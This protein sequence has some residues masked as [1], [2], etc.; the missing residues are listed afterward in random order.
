MRTHVVATCELDALDA[1]RDI[2]RDARRDADMDTRS[3][4]VRVVVPPLIAPRTRL[5][6]AD[7]LFSGFT[8]CVRPASLIH[9]V[10]QGPW[11][12][13]AYTYARFLSSLSHASSRGSAPASARAPIRADMRRVPSQFPGGESGTKPALARW[14]A[15]RRSG[16][17]VRVRG[18]RGAA[19]TCGVRG[20]RG[21]SPGSSAARG[22]RGGT[23]SPYSRGCSRV[24]SE[25]WACRDGLGV[26]EASAGRQMYW[27]M[28]AGWCEDEERGAGVTAIARGR[29]QVPVRAGIRGAMRA[30][31]GRLCAGRGW[32]EH[33]ERGAGVG[34]SRGHA[35]MYCPWRSS[36]DPPP[37]LP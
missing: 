21:A 5:G 17:Q 37:S 9:L 18:A 31:V 4:R 27:A 35:Q 36:S 22:V 34:R 16:L 8:R 32:C 6:H 19:C 29:Y 30:R 3:E 1:L 11:G 20:C 14:T 10:S 23:E 33:E 13:L 28:P 7:R 15:R 25:R 24:V 26:N 12:G 2:R